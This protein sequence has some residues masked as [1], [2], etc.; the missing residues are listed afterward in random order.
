MKS[1]ESLGPYHIVDK[2]GEGGMGE[3]YRAHDSRL[4]RTV[5]IKILAPRLA[6]VERVE[7]FEQE[8]RAASALNHPNILTIHD[9]GRYGDTAYFAM[10]WVDGRT[11][12]EAL[13]A[14]PLPHR[15]TIEL[16]QQ[17]ADGLA[18]A[19]AAG[20]VHRDL[21]P[22][23][24]MVRSSG[25]AKIV[26][27]G[28][29]KL[30]TP[31]H[32]RAAGNAE[33]TATRVALSDP[34]V[35]MGTVG[36]MSPEQASG[37]PV[38]YRSDQFALGLLIYELVTGKRPFERPTMAQ[39]LA[40]TIES[41]PPSLESLRPDVPPHLAAVVRRLLAKNPDERYESTR[42]LARELKSIV[43]TN[44][45]PVQT[46]RSRRRV[47]YAAALAAIIL[48][49]GAVLTKW[50]SRGPQPA[51]AA[52]NQR[53][54]LAVRPF[55]SL[56]P[57]P[58]QQYFA[59]GMT[60]E[61]RGQLSQIAALRLLSRN[62]LDAYKDDAPRAV[63]ELGLRHVVDGSVRVDGN[64]VRVSAELVDASTQQTLWSEQYDRDLADV[65]TVQSQIAQQIA[66][67]LQA[68]L[69][70]AEQRRIE[71]R[72]TDNLD[73]YAL[74]VQARQANIGDRA[75][76]L[77]AIERLRKALALDP[78]FA[79]ARGHL[80]YRLMFMANYDSASYLDQAIAEAET[81]VR[82]DSSLSYGHFVLGTAYGRKGL[83]AQ[84]RQAFHRAL[85]L[86]PNNTSA[87]NNFSNEEGRRSRWDE[88]AYWGRRAFL[89]SG[90]DAIDFYHL[91]NPLFNLRADPETRVLLEEAERTATYNN[92][93]QSLL[94][95][96]DVFDGQLDRAAK[97][98]DALAAHSPTNQEVKFFRA[99]FAFL[100]DAP[101]LGRWIEPLLERSASNRGMSAVS[102][103]L[104]YAY[105]LRKSGDAA[106]A[107]ALVD[108]ADRVARALADQQPDT[109][110]LRVELAAV[111]AMRQDTTGALEWLRR[112][113][114]GGY[115]DYDFLERDPIFRQQMGADA[116]FIEF[117]D[118]MRRDIATQRERAR[119]G[120]LLDLGSLGVRQ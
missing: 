119:Q 24:V 73:A 21:K 9:V 4:Q 99:E 72:P 98:A 66:R 120:G 52:D 93:I 25:L 23:N 18:A 45:T 64:R 101:D 91:I 77:E 11:L 47:A 88:A 109:T 69:S 116:R 92:R 76:N 103:R 43:E 114:D 41:D 97:R 87:M 70:P 56:S 33:P 51:V 49:A 53:P 15:R 37:R 19:H 58:Q 5:A 32:A 107:T 27:F 14:G 112:A 75:R 89:L 48:I 34:G 113:Y 13:R 110:E 68:S 10:E 86:D 3:V 83:A 71:K 67:S 29:A 80:A 6:T 102:H 63:Q 96:L 42:D 35:V 44:S 20:I 78:Q 95:W 94:V 40:A 108:E 16:V 55:R 12:R 31:A 74:F 81:A 115:R 60:E 100:L 118:R 62:G 17:I 111:S 36:Y 90:R 106:R 46:T 28:L 30:H 38:D 59:A 1:G 65:L 105:L 104:K 50:L 117:I 57:D 85:E 82:M 79:L 26:D 84:S 2:I 54:L 22:D 7:R 39:T 8:A 61:I